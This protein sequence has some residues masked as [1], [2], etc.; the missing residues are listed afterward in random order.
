MWT[1]DFISTI[2]TALTSLAAGILVFRLTGSALSVG[3]I[4][5]A[6]AVPSL[7]V[8]LIA[9]VFVDRYDRKKIM[10]VAD[11]LRGVLVFLIPFLYPYG[12]GWLYVL[13]ILS[14]ALGK[15]FDPAH[16]SVLPDVAPD[17][18]LAAANS[19]IAISSFGSTAIGFAASGLIASAISIDWAFWLDS[20]TFIVSALL[21]TRIRV[22]PL[23]IEG[24]TTV[25]TVGRNL[26][27]GF[28]YLFGT[29]IL[30]S[31]FVIY[32]PVLISFGLWNVLLLPFA[33]TELQADE[34]VY[35]IQEGLTSV[36]FVIGSLIMAV[37]ADRWREGQWVSISV[38]GMGLLG[39]L[40][41]QAS[42]I[43]VAIG[44]VMLSGFLNAPMSIGRR[45]AVQRNTT[46]EVR[47]R[48]FSS[49]IVTGDVLIMI[50]MA[51]AGLAD[52]YDVRA[53]ILAASILLLAAGTV[54]LF[55]PGVGQPA[56]QWRRAVSLLR[57]ADLAPGLGLARP[58]S[59]ADLDAL[60]RRLSAF[61]ALGNEMRAD[62]V[63]E[64]RVTEAE[65]GTAIVRRGDRTDEAYFIIEGKVAAGRSEGDNYQPLDELNAG[66]FFGEIAAITGVPRTA[67]VVASEHT[68][69]MRV[70]SGTL[71]KMMEDQDLNRLFLSKMTE[72]RPS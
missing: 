7:V 58:A 16:E 65:E 45:L 57:G 22:K 62:I 35:G 43:P 8:G 66:D 38:I 36:G 27:A 56:T 34:F 44:L 20:V 9:G 18:E 72:R 29:P 13:V 1:A 30:R 25:R 41:S 63:A 19:F 23:E 5:I 2:G 39:A 70:S 48:V 28:D 3:L 11:M 15:F 31:L 64:A 14:S 51:G 67:N 46:R 50:G 33:I 37:V 32:I 54:S 55:M 47:G 60:T 61:A 24:E 26:K 42:A 59:M 4:L 49:Y 12:I 40:Y 6:T 53:L 10:V 21:I 69:L 71:H 68:T 17:E 52:I